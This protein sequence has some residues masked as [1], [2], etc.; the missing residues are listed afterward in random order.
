M[1]RLKKQEI[2]DIYALTSMQ[3]GMLFHY[4][5]ES[6][7]EY[8]V[9]QI[10]LEISG[11]LRRD[12][13]EQA[14]NRVVESNEILRTVFRW[15]KVETPV[16][17]VLKEH[18][19]EIR[20]YN[21]E[22]GRFS[23]G[24]T[25]NSENDKN[26]NGKSDESR[27]V[28]EEVEKILTREREAGFRLE[29]VPFRV[30][31]CRKAGDRYTMIVGNH[32]ILFDGWSSGIILKEF[33]IHYAALLRGEEPLEIR[34]TK[35]K[36]YIRLREQKRQPGIL[37]KEK[38]YWREYLNGIETNVQCAV[39]NRAKAGAAGHGEAGTHRYGLSFSREWN[40]QLIQ[41]MGENKLT[42]ASVLY[43]AW[44]ILLEKYN[45]K[46][47]S[48]FGTTVSGRNAEIPGIEE[49]VGLFINTVPMRVTEAKEERLSD[50]VKRVEEMLRQRRT[51]E[52]ASLVDIKEYG[53]L[54]QQDEIFDTL[55]VIENYPLERSYFQGQDLKE[56]RIDGY[57]MEECTHYDLIL[58][59][60][61]EPQLEA[62]FSYK[63][64]HYDN[65]N[66]RR[67]GRHFQRIMEA[68]VTKSGLMVSALEVIS[69][70][71]KEQILYRFN[72]PGF[73]EPREK[74]VHRVFRDQAAALPE[75]NAVIVNGDAVSYGELNRRANSLARKLRKRGIQT[76]ELVAIMVERSLEMMAAIFAILKA[77]GAYMPISPDYPP[78]R[79]SYMLKDSR[80][81]LLL[82]HKGF[83]EKIGAGS[84]TAVLE[85][86]KSD[87]WNGDG[88]DLEQYNRY[89]DPAYVIY[90]SGSTGMPKGTII[91]H[92]SLSNRLEWMRNDYP[93]REDD[94]ILQKTPYIFDVSL[95]EL[96]LWVYDG[97][98][99]CM[100]EP[101]GEKSP[102]VIYRAIRDNNISVIH[103]VPSMLNIY[104]E[105]LEGLTKE[106]VDGQK[107]LRMVFASGEALAKTHVERFNR[108][109]NKYIKTKL[110]N[111]YGPT[112]A[113]VDV[114]WYNCPETDVPENVPIGKPIDNIVLFI[115]DKDGHFQ[116]VGVPG[117]L[118][119]GGL[120][121]A[122]GYLNKPELTAEAFVHDINYS[123][124][125]NTVSP[126]HCR[127]YKTG[128]LARWLPDGNIEFLGRMDH[129][130][131]IRGF[132]I[133]LGE[134][135][136]RLLSYPEV[137]EGV[138]I[139]RQSSDGESYLCAYIVTVSGEA[140][141]NDTLIDYMAETLP[142]YMV[143]S[144]IVWVEQMPR[145]PSGKIDRKALKTIEREAGRATGNYE[146]PRNQR[147]EKLVEIWSDVLD[148]P[149]ERI[150][151]DDNFF[152]LGG[153]SLRAVRLVSRIHRT[154]GQ[155]IP[156]TE[157]FKIPTI[158]AMS[159]RLTGEPS[160]AFRPI[161]PVEKKEYYRLSS[162]Q[163]RLYVLQ[164]MEKGSTTYNMCEVLVLEGHVDTGRFRKII[165]ALIQRHEIMRTYFEVVEGEP[166]QR[167]LDSVQFELEYY[168]PAEEFEK[169]GESG[170]QGLPGNH[171][172]TIVKRF[173]R[174]FDLGNAPLIRVGMCKETENRHLLLF[175]MHHIISDGVSVELFIEEFASIYGQ[176]TPAH[177]ELQYRDYAEWQQGN[178]NRE[179]LRSQEEYWLK[180]F[181]E[182]I[183]VLE[184]PVDYA[185]PRVLHSAGKRQILDIPAE[186]AGKLKRLALENETTL[187]AVQLALLYTF[188][189][190]ITNQES[191][192]VGTVVA[193][194]R[195][196]DLESIMGMFVNTL[197]LPAKPQANKTFRVFLNE[198][199]LNLLQ[200]LENQD[201]PFEELVNRVALKRDPGRHP[202]FDVAFAMQ[203]QDAAAI[204]LPG[205]TFSHYEY[206]TYTSKFDLLIQALEQENGIRI[207]IEYRTRLFKDETISRF[208]QYV[209]AVGAAVIKYPDVRLEDIQ[210]LSDADREQIIYEFNDTVTGYPGDKSI[211]LLFREQVARTPDAV[212][213]VGAAGDGASKIAP[214]Q[215]VTVTYRE[216]NRQANRLAKYLASKGVES[217]VIVGL[218]VRRSVSMMIGIM[219]ILKAGGAYMP[220][221][222]KYPEERINYM[223][224]DSRAVM[225]LTDHDISG[226]QAGSDAAHADSG[227]ELPEKSIRPEDIAYVIYT[228]GTTGQPKGTLTMHRN[229]V[230]VVKNTNYIEIRPEDR[231][232][233]ISSY[234][235]DGSV[236]DIYGALLNGAA[237]VQIKDGDTGSAGRIADQLEQ[238]S[239]TVFFVTTA[240]F[241]ALVDTRLRSFRRIRSV[242][243]GGENIS[244]E[245]ARKALAALGKGKIIH[246]YGPTETT[247][248]ATY[249][250]ID[251]IEENVA[252]IPI[253]YPISNTAVA[254]LDKARR[255]VPLLVYGELYISGDGVARGYLNK[256][257]LTHQSFVRLNTRSQKSQLF[258]KT[259]DIGRWLPGGSIEFHGRVDQQVKIRGYRIEPREIEYAL[260]KHN[261][262]TEA[263]VQVR[264]SE[265]GEKYLCAYYVSTAQM[266]SGTLREFLSAAIPE[267]MI[268]AHYV[269]LETIPLN[270][271]GKVDQ[272][273]LP[274]PEIE[275][276]T[277]YAAPTNET[278][279][280]LVNI[281]LQLLEPLN[282]AVGIDD[283]FFELG[284]H[285]IKATLMAAKIQEEMNVEIALTDIFVSPTIRGL[286]ACIRKS[287]G[288]IHKPIP[289]VEQKE[290]YPLSSAQKR[291]YILQ[292]MDDQGIGYNIPSAW[293]LE[294]E[295]DKN[296]LTH[297]FKSL[298]RKHE[299]F[300]T[301]FIE[302]NHEPVQRIHDHV[303]FKIEENG[304]LQQQSPRCRDAIYRV[305][306]GPAS[307]DE[308]IAKARAYVRPFDLTRAPLLRV[309][310]ME[311]DEGRHI[312]V[313]DMHHIIADGTTVEIVAR[314]FAALYSGQEP[315]EQKLQYKDYTR[316][317]AENRTGEGFLRQARYWLKEFESEI[318][319]LNLPTDYP[320][321]AIQGFKGRTLQFGLGEENTE[322]LRK[323]GMADGATMFMVL[324]AITSV[325]LSK[326]SG[327]ED[328]VIGTPIAGRRH[329]D[330]EHMTGMF[331]NTLAMRNTP[332]GNQTFKEFLGNVKQKSL[333]AYE[334]QDYQYE[335][336]VEEADIQRDAGRNPLFDVAYS[337]QGADIVNRRLPDLQLTPVELDTGIS[338]FDLTLFGIESRNEVTFQLEYSTQL[339]TEETIKRFIGYF[340]NT[341]AAAAANP[342]TS[343]SELQP[344][345]AEEK[346][347]LLYDFNDT[348]A[349]YETGKTMH[350][351]FEEQVQ[352]TPHRIAVI[353][354]TVGAGK[355]GQLLHLSYEEL[356]HRSDL[357]A[358]HLLQ[359]R[360]END[361][362][363]YVAVL[364]DRSA[365]MIVT[366]LAILKSGSAYVPI[367]PY[368]PESRIAYLLSSLN[369]GRLITHQNHYNR[370]KTTL[371]LLPDL[372]TVIGI[373]PMG[374]LRRLS[375]GPPAARGSLPLD[376]R[377][378]LREVCVRPVDIAYV[379]FTS[380]STGVPKGVVVEHRPVINLIEWVNRYTA[381]DGRDKQLFVTSLGFDLSVYDIFGILAAGAA[382]RVVEAGDIK[383]PQKLL[384]IIYRESITFWDSAPAALQQLVAFFPEARD[385]RQIS[386]LRHVFLS[387]DWVPLT[388][389]NALK[390]TFPG[391]NVTALGGATEATVW[392]NFFPVEKVEPHWPSI[393]YGKPI[394]NAAYYILDT[395]GSATPLGVPGDLYIGGQCLASGYINDPQ[396]TDS[397][398]VDNPFIPGTKMYKTGD[399]A[400][401][402]NN[403]NMEFLGRN[404][405]QVK[406]RGYRIELGEIENQILN[407]ETVKESVVIA[408]GTSGARTNDRQLAAYIVPNPENAYPV[409]QWL[410]MEN[411]G[412]LQNYPWHQL[413]NG[414]PVFIRNRN[415]TDFMYGEIYEEKAY[416]Q[417]GIQL[418]D[419]AVV[420]DIGANI[421]LFSLYVHQ[422]VNNAEIFA[423]E[424]IPPISELLRLN[425]SLYGA[426]VNVLESGAASENGE[427]EFTYYPNV[428][429]LSGRFAGYEEEKEAVR[430]YIFNHQF[431]P[432]SN[433][434]NGEELSG[435]QLDELL[436]N[437]LT[438]TAITRPLTTIS[439]VIRRND[440][441]RIDL[442]KI[443]VEKSENDVLAGI[444][445]QHWPIIRQLVVEVHDV[446]GRLDNVVQQLEHRGYR[447]TVEQENV[448]SETKFFHV[449]AILPKE[450]TT[451]NATVVDKEKTGGNLSEQYPVNARQLTAQ[452]KQSLLEKLPEYM[453]PQH[454]VLMERFPLTAN[455]KVDRKALPEPVLETDTQYAAPTDEIE[456]RL[457][458][459]WND[460]LG[461]D[462]PVGIDT[463]FF[464]TGGHSLNATTLVSKIHKTFDVKIPLAEI[465]RVPDIRGQAGYIRQ[466]AKARF[467]A[468]RKVEEREYYPLSS[469]Q[470][471]Q[472]LLYRLDQQNR[473]YNMPAVLYMEG[474][475]DA[476]KLEH[477]FKQLIRNHES[478]RTGFL[479][480]DDEPVQRIHPEVEFQ[481]EQVTAET[482]AVNTPGQMPEPERV[483]TM[484]ES[485]VRP[486]DL[487]SAPLLRVRQVNLREGRHLLM[488]DMH[489]IISDG[490][491]M[492]LLVNEFISRYNNE[493]VPASPVE[494]KDYAQW[495]RH[496]ME[497]G[498]LEKQEKYWLQR[499]ADD[500]PVLEIPTD[501]PR[502]RLQSYEGHAV[503]IP[504]SPTETD[505]LR[506][507]AQTEESTLFM[508][509]LAIFKTLLARLSNQEEIVVGTAAAGR[510]TTDLEHTMGMFVNTLAIRTKPRS[511]KTYRE[512]LNDIKRQTLD[513]FENQEYQFEELVER[514]EIERNTGRNPLFDVMFALQNVN[515]R[516]LEIPGLKLTPMDYH[517]GM[518]KFDLVFNCIEE[519]ESLTIVVEYATRLFKENTIRHYA[520]YF[521]RIITGVLAD[522]NTKLGEIELLTETEKTE[523]LGQLN[524]PWIEQAEEL[525]VS[526]LHD[527][528]QRQAAATPENI[529]VIL[530]NEGTRTEVTYREL[531]RR[532]NRLAH[533][534]KAGGVTGDTVVGILM[535]RSV[536]MIAAILAVLKAGGAYLPLDPTYPEERIRFMLDDSGA[537]ILLTAADAMQNH[538]YTRLQGIGYDE[539]Q[540][541]IHATPPRP[542]ILDLD[543]QPNVDR[544][545]VDYEKY[546]EK[547]GMAM[548]KQS[549]ALQATRGCPYHC[550]YC[551]KI[552]PKKHVYRSAENLFDEIS[553]CYDAGIK[554]FTLIDDIFN[555]N[556]A[557]SRRFFE[558]IAKSRLDVQL[559]FPN[560]V[561]GDILTKEYIDLMVEAGT[562][563]LAMAL[564]T[565]SPRLQ[566]MIG[567]NMNL[568]K[569][570]ENLEYFCHRHP[571]VILELFSMHGFPTET[572]SEAQTTLEFIKSLKW[573]HFPYFHILKIYPSTDM[574]ELARR[575][576]IPDAT[577]AR[578]AGQAYHQ[579]PATL[580]FDK[581]F[582][583]QCQGEFLNRY[584]LDK[585]RLRHVLP[586]QLKVLEENEL[587]QKYD[588]YL[589]VE[590][591]SL[592]D[593]LTFAGLKRE[594]LGTPVEP[595][596]KYGA[597][598]TD[599]N[600]RMKERFPQQPPEKDALR[601]LLL[602][603]S[604]YYGSDKRN[605]LYDVVEPPL[606]LM[607][608]YTAL[609]KELGTGVDV[610][611]AKSR[612]DFDSD[613]ELK[614]MVEE[615]KPD[616]IGLRTLTYYKDFFHRTAS[617]I[618][619]WQPGIPLIAGGPYATSDTVSLLKDRNI[620]LVVKGEGERTLCELMTKIKVNGK[621]LPTREQLKEIAGIVYVAKD[622]SRNTPAAREIIML[623]GMLDGMMDGG[624]DDGPQEKE[625]LYENLP[626]TGNPADMAY[627]IYTSGTTGRP[628]G[629]MVE[630]RNIA[631]L[632]TTGKTLFD[633][634]Q[635]D[636]WTMYHSYCFD[637]SV[638]EMYGALLFGG[639]LV[640]VPRMVARDPR[641]YRQLIEKER[642]TV[643]NQTPTVF[644]RLVDEEMKQNAAGLSVRCVIFGGEALQPGMLKTWKEKYPRTE[645]INMYGITETTVHVTYKEITKK[646]IELDISNIG[647]PIASLWCAV[648]NRHGKLQP[649]GV[650][651]ELIVGGDGVAR[652][653]MNRSGLTEERF[654][655]DFDGGNIATGRYYRS[656]DLVRMTATGEMEY[657][658]R[659][660]HQV[661]IRGNRVELGEIER[662]ILLQEDVP[663]TAAL[664]MARQNDNGE[665]YVCAYL[666]LKENTSRSG[667]P[668]NVTQLRESL[669]RTMPDYML[670]SYFIPLEEFPVTATGKVDR[671]K[672]PLPEGMRPTLNTSYVAPE[673]ETARE[674]ATIWQ[675]ILNLEKV[676]IHDNFFDLGGNSLDIVRLNNRLQEVM[677]REIPV[678]S[679]FEYPTIHTFST[680]LGREEKMEAV[681]VEVETG[682]PLLQEKIKKGRGKMKDRRNRLR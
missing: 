88:T 276:G 607:H 652:G 282:T 406:I 176:K 291:I 172:G 370:L 665:N 600:L 356:N 284:G 647:H 603:L 342:E 561:R 6:G 428:S 574:A 469:A 437:R 136:N 251:R 28:E 641:Q 663:M 483:K 426:N 63:P 416:V 66:I 582:T 18:R 19:P 366:V 216:L 131:K 139:P 493:T 457:L 233:Q 267:Y 104:L 294:G 539:E 571:Q 116:P 122:R 103:F 355:T 646:E 481:L 205:L 83:Q 54:D 644:Y 265:T 23:D 236:F 433:S 568:E 72:N 162:A 209:G 248:Y 511:D 113:T 74:N 595:E 220:I 56:L 133:E 573:L 622:S 658:G 166:V 464:D 2:Q 27:G 567:K 310:L 188:L 431:D 102:V 439:D 81:R 376:P 266:E 518:T 187:F 389:P 61:T 473:G 237:L 8:Y 659:I 208:I 474:R 128:D 96:F 387:G 492:A 448:M 445:N 70:E 33:F 551:H 12:Y 645:L 145:T 466:A 228:S 144:V 612:I 217:G 399:L 268:P 45:N 269:R 388:M 521:K 177:L 100:L 602:D 454:F 660:D 42:L 459:I 535:E 323:I 152:R 589:P 202:V 232:L 50:R 625:D 490:T 456:S 528:F 241:N 328:N 348:A 244:V 215:T 397:K 47:E 243:F 325:F 330:L 221:D 114:S 73:D 553:Q 1:R 643:L 534:L 7:A 203:D 486:F 161:E 222:A 92:H 138:V 476:R 353:G 363:R 308:T 297:A 271:N 440:V 455:G 667:E 442:L 194:R 185:R 270:P 174:P 329:A 110:I 425:V 98:A 371:E 34:K 471:R 258:Y 533:R 134:I 526:T 601:L 55:V 20:Y 334:N 262:I 386:R 555:L 107:R 559:F 275:T 78:E 343:L 190:K 532:A 413:P 382:I 345:T 572:E 154:F 290:Y 480:I 540:P 634:G 606:G 43:T 530:E 305:H 460:I 129:Q 124:H 106:E 478:L 354:P 575:Q 361:A 633:Y 29:E 123:P 494:Y 629:V 423:F 181:S 367:E 295:L 44:G 380:G 524:R 470:K 563:S 283:N 628:K 303:E 593:L 422:T 508:V 648:V 383:N 419:G 502:P 193:G 434:Q 517:T 536:E 637:F 301:S 614:R 432:E 293:Q 632:M 623:D 4:L 278:E 558:K 207:N 314:E 140:M 554:R 401:W 587:V 257:E 101:G 38:T 206:E 372:K 225:I 312:M 666:K 250:P 678:V 543:A 594:E 624:M 544:S 449:F 522:R 591:R 404:D 158:R 384:D 280:R 467:D 99:L 491:T 249:Y 130:V 261:D 668:L 163:Q 556:E 159:E 118:R 586:Y 302:I 501:Y 234:A 577:I 605:M 609:K 52:N 143:P 324:M 557:N 317:Q 272:R 285:S 245:H 681:P 482:G 49:M 579:L 651:G 227:L 304:S 409:I 5:R 183:P 438:G 112:E 338:K 68:I 560:G 15:E 541:E 332:T 264:G 411:N 592:Q 392:S 452:L 537:K 453:V 60:I 468:I 484:I 548:V 315:T 412:T 374:C 184:L 662:R 351:L 475:P 165:A 516:K 240:M 550:A 336:L 505:A 199:H 604:Q 35:F 549:F 149:K 340:K 463:S 377:L 580:P 167:I 212:A 649:Q 21:V 375:E 421:G 151:I 119:I 679:L 653:Y 105:Y 191:M 636:T 235:F 9:E 141:E 642:V 126:I 538:S 321:P 91:E 358:Q 71:E 656:G 22:N 231:I 13:F 300:R 529:A 350:Q 14:W 390:E 402:H 405:N 84:D 503:K 211:T 584:F 180:V 287:A 142:E 618:H 596:K 224:E 655:K 451:G 311:Q 316:W 3:E 125:R 680:H 519:N 229:V 263:H 674:I 121:L 157:V 520:G 631:R 396:L 407:N 117:E 509:L 213:Y 360:R 347:R 369:V 400:R 398:F 37:E 430:T 97:A 485:F 562:T 17:V 365:E 94:V 362:N 359:E 613:K 499:F 223:R 599:L 368:L 195:R 156:V 672:L 171:H 676:G 218:K 82:T 472:Y 75:N 242:L 132:R 10:V 546:G 319:L 90:T 341:V 515:V 155:E 635:K 204:R 682:G 306:P 173:V 510:I 420:F 279:V 621:K 80:A 650:A 76:G 408:R 313:V 531:N 175:D 230:R 657:L 146:A 627:I 630:H 320:R 570:R 552:W 640:I 36:E 504:V 186:A 135:E 385:R 418:E 512:Y 273:A 654:A 588:S 67:M 394:Q 64:Q 120:G 619:E 87:I 16:Q 182:E 427:A 617:R 318:P 169:Q 598:V 673:T 487:A 298:I 256:P 364:V 477:T 357:L 153:H 41:F 48:L 150:G 58:A 179:A 417:Q 585:E 178:L 337:L 565:A 57:R 458:E 429:I 31:L 664:V 59:V 564:E 379:I 675:E 410:R 496:R 274:E 506:K 246:V 46:T 393:P 115:V 615:F 65:E 307:N 95:W 127:S 11:E 238:E 62:V 322:L 671:K 378:S 77:G 200:A 331:V 462:N 495:Q 670:P 669:A 255:P 507:L 498:E 137:K 253:G 289:P 436:R 26:E 192:V 219:G 346:K 620:S 326:L 441:Q 349:H 24:V 39:K 639:K 93:M 197:A 51:Y 465:F 292:Q 252:T 414:M 578:S 79:I 25:G 277:R 89:D 547:I 201:Y 286:A 597:R 611:I 254:I 259:G 513:A 288:K 214:I 446:G 608:L 32:H 461:L 626:G 576:G 352:R 327:Q 450:I 281:W 86:E 443:N 566:Q 616:I 296:R 527:Y 344:L 108:V 545:A 391:V 489:H 164:Q 381:V 339:F 168:E 542:Q 677:K 373:E 395:Y 497:T 226:I 415:E 309:G 583:L 109:L 160:S 148:S 569:L 40:R 523:I 30:T 299:S 447:V 479:M 581:R 661:K 335:D 590:I 514:V 500:I 69:E 260:L 210:L 196:T 147:E 170:G 53:R 444:E 239:I 403:G 525:P 111:L 85:L 610:K 488:V 198:I 247:V 435:D 189:Y 333:Q 424:P 638:W